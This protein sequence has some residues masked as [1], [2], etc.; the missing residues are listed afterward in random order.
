[1]TVVVDKE[2]ARKNRRSLGWLLLVVAVC[3]GLSYFL[4]PFLAEELV[5]GKRSA[6][7]F[8]QH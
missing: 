3:F 5:H 7:H 8:N 2:V 6:E 1:M 4:R